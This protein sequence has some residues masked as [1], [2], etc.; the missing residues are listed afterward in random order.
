MAIA[1][2]ITLNTVVYSPRGTSNGVTKWAKPGDAGFG[3]GQSELTMSVKGPL[4]DGKNRV[5]V[6]LT[7]PKLA[8]A[9]SACA[10]TGQ[11]LGIFQLNANIDLPGS[12]TPAERQDFRKRIKDYFAS[13]EFTAAVDNLEAPWG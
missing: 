6:I 8:T 3:G 11:Q 12:A 2:A 10:C 13:A 4:D 1:A 9:D 7:S 5:R